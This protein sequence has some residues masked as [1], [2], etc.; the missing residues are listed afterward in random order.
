MNKKNQQNFWEV[1]LNTNNK[2]KK[3][4][5]IGLNKLSPNIIKSITKA[6]KYADIVIVGKKIKGFE[7]IESDSIEPL[8]QMAK[9]KKIDAVVRGNFDAVDAYNA[10]SKVLNFKDSI[11]EINFFK[12]NGV[13]MIDNTCSG[14]FCLLPVSFTNE[15]S[16]KDK[17]RSIDLHL[18]FFKKNKITPKIGILA[19][20]KPA[21]KKS[22]VPEVTT[23]LKEAD[24]LVNYYQKRKVWVKH[25]NHQIEYAVQEAN[26]IVAQNSW[27]GNLAAHC[28][29]YLG[30]TEYLGGV[31]SNL[32]DIIYIDD[33]EAME[34]YSNCIIMANYLATVNKSKK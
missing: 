14:V 32:K 26:I 22:G 27:A 2:K 33:S 18:D 31:G 12:L 28:L 17:I 16:V 3:R 34:D 23:G 5:G 29:L 6:K 25:F 9:D 13:N 15:R 20:G 21:D 30:S 4:V 7:C 1:A 24:F 8:I 11:L 19:P 10:V